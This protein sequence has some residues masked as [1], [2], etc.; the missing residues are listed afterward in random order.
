MGNVACSLPR[1]TCFTVSLFTLNFIKLLILKTRRLCYGCWTAE[2]TL[3]FRASAGTEPHTSPSSSPPSVPPFFSLLP[4][5]AH[6]W[7]RV[8]FIRP[9]LSLELKSLGAVTPFLQYRSTQVHCSLA[10]NPFWLLFFIGM[11]GFT[12][13]KSTGTKPRRKKSKAAGTPRKIR[14]PFCTYQLPNG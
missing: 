8:T 12:T 1:P 4:N 11:T 14:L 7:R 13:A 9:C 2:I 10:I 3:T 5:G 6:H